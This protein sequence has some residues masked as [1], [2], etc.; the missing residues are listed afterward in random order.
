M[1]LEVEIIGRQG[2][3]SEG[4]G[5]NQTDSSPVECWLEDW[6]QVS[7]M[8]KSNDKS[9]TPQ[10]S[11]ELIPKGLPFFERGSFPLPF[12]RKPHDFG[13]P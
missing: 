5:A 6:S 4:R 12:P 11:N 8:N 2:A 7:G 9:G 3:P 1:L 13:C 10:K